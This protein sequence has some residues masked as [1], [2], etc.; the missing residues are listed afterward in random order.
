MRMR[1]RT[2]LWEL[3]MKEICITSELPRRQPCTRELTPTGATSA[4]GTWQ[5]CGR[6]LPTSGR[7]TSTYSEQP[8][9]RELPASLRPPTFSPQELL[10][11]LPNI[12]I[13]RNVFSS[14][15]THWLQEIGTALGT[16]CACSYT[17]LSYALHEVHNIMAH[18]HDFLLMLKS[19]IN[20]MFRTWVGNEEEEW[21]Q[22]QKAIDGF[23]KL[24]WIFSD[25]SNSVV[26]LDLTLTTNAQRTI[27]KKTFVKPKNL[28]LYIPVNSAHPPGCFKGT[29]FGN[30]I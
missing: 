8:G 25:L 5:P 29:I 2:R 30:I 18:F 13:I 23:G 6:T 11:T 7:A 12:I 14:D 16:P 4:T 19:F 9:N 20:D 17:T 10:I 22:F 21:E 24:K 1:M 3:P 26:F 15:D 28:H 27:E